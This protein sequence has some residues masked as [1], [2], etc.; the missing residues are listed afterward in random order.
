[1]LNSLADNRLSHQLYTLNNY[2]PV[3]PSTWQTELCGPIEEIP[4]RAGQASV[5]PHM[6]R[7]A[8][9]AHRWLRRWLAANVPASAPHPSQARSVTI[10]SPPP[11]SD[12]FPVQSV[13]P[14][15]LTINFVAPEV[16]TQEGERGRRA[17]GMV[18]SREPVNPLNRNPTGRLCCSW[19]QRTTAGR[20]CTGGVAFTRRPDP[21]VLAA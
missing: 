5:L 12:H 18:S 1:M 13:D 7:Q 2:H 17:W 20:R 21:C 3:M 11:I 6:T 19:R 16:L 15:N 9:Q 10:Q 4:L 8:G 14:R